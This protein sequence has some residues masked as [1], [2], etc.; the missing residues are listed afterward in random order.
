MRHYTTHLDGDTL[1]NAFD[2]L[3]A[4]SDCY[5][6]RFIEPEP[7][8]THWDS[9]PQFPAELS[10]SYGDWKEVSEHTPI[11]PSKVF[12]MTQYTGGS[13][14]S[15]DLVEVSNYKAMLELLPSDY[16]DGVDYI[17]YS[18]GHRTF[19]LAIRIDRLTADI[20][21]AFKSLEDYPLLDESLHSELEM[22]SQNEAW[23]SDIK[24]DFRTALGAQMWSVYESSPKAEQRD[25]ETDGDY[26]D[27][28]DEIE[29]YLSDECGEIS[30][31]DLLELCW[32]MADLANEYWVNEQGSDSYLGVD[33]VI[34][35]SLCW[36][37]TQHTAQ[38]QIDY[39]RKA[40]AEIKALLQTAMSD[41][42]YDLGIMR[43]V[44][45]NQMHLEF[46]TES[47]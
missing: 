19:D 16:E 33:A 22:E 43:V 18:G 10:S 17:T 45:P 5:N 30:D 23:E 21:E 2:K 24:A 34:K 36:T 47:N 13:D 3:C 29:E 9:K 15:G 32:K 26:Q 1:P 27:R 14:Y 31:C 35:G 6:V 28:L 8:W 39:H 46:R 42:K 44:D 38:W 37:A 11:D 7:A 20:L 12:V 40:Y 4:V 41:R 25:G